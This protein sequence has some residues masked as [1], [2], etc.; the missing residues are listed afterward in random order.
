MVDKICN[1][2]TS[3]I[4][5]EDQS[6]DD[7]RAEII[8]FGV[9]L[10]VGEIPKIFIMV[11][12]AFLLGVGKLAA[13][14]FL[15]ILP[16]RK[17][18]GGFHLKTH[19]GCIICTTLMYAGTA[20][21]AKYFPITGITKYICVIVNLIYGV[22]MITKYA[23]A[24]TENIPILTKKERKSKRI[25]SYIVLVILL[26]ASVFIKEQTISSIIIYGLFIQTTFI[27]KLAY[28][29]TNNK[30]GYEVYMNEQMKIA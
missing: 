14:S 22:I 7:E 21:L 11:A 28:K 13:I 10:I 24:D 20:L 29:I 5:E 25:L 8:N 12:I 23:P 30:Y 19:I 18:S 16:Y 1:F 9:Q 27:T 26:V 17:F 6:I 15:L 3:K 2:L 4:R